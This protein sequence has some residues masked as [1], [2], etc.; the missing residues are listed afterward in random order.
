MRK[1][2]ISAIVSY[3]VI[4]LAVG[5]ANA[6]LVT[7]DQIIFQNGAG[8]NPGLL[9]G[10]VDVT[11]SGNTLTLLLK[12]TSPD[13]AFTNAGSPSLMLLSGVG[14][15][16]P[17]VNIVDGTVAVNGTPLNFEA[18]Q[19]TSDI[20]NQ[21]NFANQSTA[22]WNLPG[23]L[24]VDTTMSSVQNGQSTR[25]GIP[26]ATS[27]NSINGPDYGALSV[28]ETQFGSSQSAVR[29]AI[30]I[31]LN[32]SGTAPSVATIDA[33]NVVLAFGSP[34]AVPDGGSTL[35]LLG[36]TLIGGEFLRRRIARNSPSLS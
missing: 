26:P 7:V 35:V 22:G 28:L 6:T 20:S 3:C 27:P 14:L 13:A 18:G 11:S 21:W 23:V 31:V 4:F 8:V 17:G 5:S 36:L 19:S 1:F 9:S 25:F 24:A 32:L 30:Q 12:N 33:G 29:D 15:Q 16:L 2:R 34:N 10:T